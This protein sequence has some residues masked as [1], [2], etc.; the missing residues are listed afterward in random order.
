MQSAE[1]RIQIFALLMSGVQI[2]PDTVGK[3]ERRL[4]HVFDTF[5]AGAQERM[6]NEWNYRP[7]L[8]KAGMRELMAMHKALKKWDLLAFVRLWNDMDDT[9]LYNEVEVELQKV[10]TK[11]QIDLIKQ[12]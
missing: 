8:V 4:R 11:D 1:D 9:Y 7:A 6:E 2:L 12:F 3:T 10:L 5:M